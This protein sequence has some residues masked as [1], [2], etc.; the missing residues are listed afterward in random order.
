MSD[1]YLNGQEALRQKD[2]QVKQLQQELRVKNALFANANDVFAELR[3][4]HPT[5]SS[6]FLGQGID[7][8]TDPN[9]KQILQLSVRTSEPLSSEDQIRIENWFKV[10]NED[11]CCTIKFFGKSRYC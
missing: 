8:P 4:Q 9:Q 5:V 1:L 3:A 2:E 10:Q 7:L 11:R 6:I